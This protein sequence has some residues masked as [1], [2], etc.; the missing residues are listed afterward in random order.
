M[1]KVSILM[2]KATCVGKRYTSVSLVDGVG[3]GSKC[4]KNVPPDKQML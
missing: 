1:A 4:P 3:M 2:K